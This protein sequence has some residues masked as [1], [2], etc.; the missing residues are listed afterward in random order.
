LA[1]PGAEL[2]DVGREAV[3]GLASDR[4]AY[5][6]PSLRDVDQTA[7][8]MH[9]GSL[10]SLAAVVEHYDRGGNGHPQQDDQILPIGLSAEQLRNL[11]AFLKEGLKSETY[12]QGE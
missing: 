10:S 8:Y 5:K 12:P 11:V 4:G 6:T 2:A 1:S 3:T 7:P 9:N